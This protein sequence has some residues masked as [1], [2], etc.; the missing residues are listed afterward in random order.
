MHFLFTEVYLDYILSFNF[1]LL[2]CEG[3]SFSF[4]HF[5]SSTNTETS[6]TKIA[7][8]ILLG[9]GLNLIVLRVLF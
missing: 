2:F 9:V 7:V 4:C 5:K 6:K 8:A 3:K 1:Y